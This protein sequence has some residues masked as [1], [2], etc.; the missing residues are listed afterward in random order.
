LTGIF[1][2][3]AF[4]DLLATALAAHTGHEAVTLALVDLNDFKSVNDE[5]GHLAG[6][7]VLQDV[8]RRLEEAAHP[9]PVFRLGG[10]EFAALVCGDSAAKAKDA[11]QRIEA[12]LT[13]FELRVASGMLAQS[14]SIGVASTSSGRS[15]PD[16][17][18]READRA[19]YTAKPTGGNIRS[20]RLVAEAAG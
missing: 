8:A 15:R 14:T 1:N 19:M 5:H 9:H 4:N 6:D 12:S 3:R 20:L 13:Q 11:V 10:D 17:L 16:R 7:A 2:R 18:L